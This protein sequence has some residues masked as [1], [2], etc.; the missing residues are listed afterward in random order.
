MADRP[1]EVICCSNCQARFRVPVADYA[2][3]GMCKKCGASIE[4]PATPAAPP[5]DP[6][7]GGVA[8]GYT[9]L[10]LSADLASDASAYGMPG[11]MTAA[12]PMALPPLPTADSHDQT[13]PAG[14]ADPGRPAGPPPLP[15]SAGAASSPMSAYT[16]PPPPPPPTSPT[17]PKP[18]IFDIE[19]TPDEPR[20][21]ATPPLPASSPPPLVD[22]PAPPAS[23]TPPRA[24]PID[25]RPA[26]R[27]ETPAPA[28]PRRPVWL[29]AGSIA[30][31]VG[32]CVAVWFALNREPQL[33]FKPPRGSGRDTLS[34]NGVSFVAFN[35]STHRAD[36]E[37]SQ[38]RLTKLNDPL[39]EIKAKPYRW[40]FVWQGTGPV[41]ASELRPPGQIVDPHLMWVRQSHGEHVSRGERQPAG[42][43]RHV[44]VVAARDPDVP[45]YVAVV[46]HPVDDATEGDAVLFL[47]D[48][49]RYPDAVQNARP[50]MALMRACYP[51]VEKG[52]VD[53]VRH[54]LSLSD[55]TI[56]ARYSSYVDSRL[57]KL[58]VSQAQA[59]RTEAAA[60]LALLSDFS[61]TQ[62]LF[63]LREDGLQRDEA[64]DLIHAG[65]IGR[66]LDADVATRLESLAK[67]EPRLRIVLSEVHAF[68]TLEMLAQGRDD[69][70]D[71]DVRTARFWFDRQCHDAPWVR[72][73]ADRFAQTLAT[74]PNDSPSLRTAVE[75]VGAR[76]YPRA[77]AQ[78][79]TRT[80]AL[81]GKPMPGPV[82]DAWEAI[83][84][85]DRDVDRAGD[86][87][88]QAERGKE[89]ERWKSTLLELYKLELLGDERSGPAERLGAQWKLQRDLM[90]A[91]DAAQR[92]RSAAQARE[93]AAKLAA[94]RAALEEAKRRDIERAR[95]A[96]TSRKATTPT[97]D[98][99]PTL[100][101]EWLDGYKR[102]LAAIDAGDTRG[103][104]RLLASAD[105][106]Q[107]LNASDHTHP[108]LLACAITR[109]NIDMVRT[110]LDSG[111][112]VEDLSVCRAA[113]MAVNRGGRELVELLVRAGVPAY[114]SP[115]NADA[116]KTSD[117][118]IGQALV[119]ERYDIAE[120]LLGHIVDLHYDH[121]RLFNDMVCLA[122]KQGNETRIKWLLDHGADIELPLRYTPLG[123]AIRQ[124]CGPGVTALLK[125]GARTD[126]VHPNGL[127]ALELAVMTDYWVL[128]PYLMQHGARY[129][130]QPMLPD[131][132]A[133]D[134]D[135]DP[136]HLG[137]DAEGLLGI[138]RLAVRCN[139]R[140]VLSWVIKQRIDLTVKQGPHQRTL[141]HYAAL[142]PIDAVRTMPGR[143]N[144]GP[145]K[146]D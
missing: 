132:T 10:D 41:H 54:V 56:A 125:F 106:A 16:P 70:P 90:R 80:K 48:A 57:E 72:R 120:F 96:T 68:A 81:N 1:T 109:G 84:S 4:I 100:G 21:L 25:E 130:G 134:P 143:E 20:T 111:A 131:L 73:L 44:A 65:V 55:E 34:V 45:I 146:I 137:P 31:I 30:A 133:R 123:N 136:S 141:L 27:S 71:T 142:P 79:F 18:G 28:P 46:S 93:R 53:Y 95:S 39:F 107:D 94:S 8:Q 108:R 140:Q 66:R 104:R 9:P 129:D 43:W 114:L 67:S 121:G 12:A 135:G 63:K 119:N 117:T 36:L 2:Q 38:T 83:L 7:Q 24:R 23:V 26:A 77:L 82:A 64:C 42:A 122:G 29:I 5:A 88:L 78:V 40:V 113:A 37:I 74:L 115:D 58:V 139:S 145:I 69:L 15:T 59:I 51:R 99:P 17:A 128:V 6:P 91:Y 92:Q 112:S 97:V 87:D 52:W 102:L 49:I 138:A 50:V 3:R 75:V 14:F 62:A 35:K 116:M 126:S 127:S 33:T 85:L 110:L 13:E 101:D 76:D 47:R 86:A 60:T 22:P 89:I 144:R 32:V 11:D 124:P 61:D 118:M 98:A 103:F 105:C 19:P